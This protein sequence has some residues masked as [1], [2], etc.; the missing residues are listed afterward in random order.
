MSYLVILLLLLSSCTASQYLGK[1]VATA[2]KDGFYYESNK[3]QEGMNAQGKINP[4]TGEMAFD[5]KT[6]STTPE[7][8]IAA[9]LQT[10]LEAQK[11]LGVILQAIMPLLQQAA[12]IG[13]TAAGGPAAGAAVKVLTTPPPIPAAP[14]GTTATPIK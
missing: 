12:Q 14:S 1:T 2:N 13:A 6:T 9:A 7:A 4:A 10:N 3:N 5:V 8:A 11:Q